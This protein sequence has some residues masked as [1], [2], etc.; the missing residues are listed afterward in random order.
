MNEMRLQ[1]E[2]SGIRLCVALTG[3]A[4]SP[5]MESSGRPRLKGLRLN[6][7]HRSLSLLVLTVEAF[8]RSS[9]LYAINEDGNANVE[10]LALNENET[11]RKTDDILP[12]NPVLLVKEPF[13]QTTT[14]GGYGVRMDC[15]SDITFLAHDD[16]RTPLQWLPRIIRIHK[17]A[18]DWKNEGNEAMKLRNACS[19]ITRYV[20]L[21]LVSCNT[22]MV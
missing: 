10:S 9:A 20:S 11:A 17:K 14:C 13:L 15:V 18:E 2:H 7:H 19:A 12:L 1:A 4:N 22:T 8:Y 5:S 6:I 16:A 21:I 3:N